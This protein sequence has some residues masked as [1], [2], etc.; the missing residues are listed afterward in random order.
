[1]G[2]HLFSGVWYSR[3]TENVPHLV[4]VDSETSMESMQSYIE[5]QGRVINP[6][7]G[8]V[9]LD[10][11]CQ[12]GD[13]A[14]VE[15][16]LKRGIDPNER[17]SNTNATTLHL[18]TTMGHLDIVEFLL[19]NKA[20]VN[21][22]NRF[23]ETSVHNA[24]DFGHANVLR[25]LLAH[26]NQ[27]CINSVTYKRQNYGDLREIVN[28]TALEISVS[29]H[30]VACTEIL[31][32]NAA[33]YNQEIASLCF[34]LALDEDHIGLAKLLVEQG[35]DIYKGFGLNQRTVLH[36]AAIKG[37]RAVAEQLLDLGAD[38]NAR[39]K[40]Q[41][42][43]IQ[44]A[45]QK[46]HAHIVEFFLQ[47]GC[48]VNSRDIDGNT[49]LHLSSLKGNLETMGVLLDGGARSDIRNKTKLLPHHL[50]ANNDRQE[51]LHVLLC[52]GCPMD[53][54]GSVCSAL[55]LVTIRN[56]FY[57][58]A[59]LLLS[60]GASTNELLYEVGLV[61]MWMCGCGRRWAGTMLRALLYSGNSRACHEDSLKA[62]HR[63]RFTVG[64]EVWGQ[65]IS[66]T[67]SPQPLKVGARRQIR[68]R[69][70]TVH[71]GRSIWASIDRLPLPRALRE[72]LKLYDLYNFAKL[73]SK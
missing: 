43:P 36:D 50:C 24:V 34:C 8:K 16:L 21:L 6:A 39:D 38:V 29:Q 42:T 40:N 69:L 31:L 5:Q 67:N 63:W 26:P 55:E 52:H 60:H 57:D 22:V 58:C 14:L 56:Q 66:H 49:A 72:F 27:K 23:G 11:A 51:A 18:A 73:D 59:I 9:Y 19:E 37:S 54:R 2:N 70:V 41:M 4:E 44:Y 35:F 71:R 17:V 48:E 25:V 30:D 33:Q 62:M 45:S 15:L 3:C 1:M 10:L 64:E 61:W 12:T 46:A 28:V 47:R 20:D 53:V 65:I 32:Q 68:H 13:V 7:M